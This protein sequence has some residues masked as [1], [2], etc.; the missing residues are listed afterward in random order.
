[1]QDKTDAIRA[2][3]GPRAAAFLLDRLLLVIALLSVRI[4]ALFA[5]GGTA[6]LFRFT[7]VDVLCYVLVCIYFILLTHFTGST[8]GKKVMGLRVEKEDGEKPSLP[9]VI[10]RETIGRYL[11]SILFLGYFMV[12]AD[13]RQRA[14]HDYLCDT[15]V[16][17]DRRV[18]HPQPQANPEKHA[19]YT[20]PGETQVGTE[21]VP[22]IPPKETEAAEPFYTIPSTSL[23]KDTKTEE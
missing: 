18:I 23:A 3:F 21:D 14:F 17:Y 22:A 10:Y 4:P 16:V 6:I 20:V 13:S 5:G 2:G 11:S 8:L 9:D 12:L 1:M 7:A 19:D 15:R